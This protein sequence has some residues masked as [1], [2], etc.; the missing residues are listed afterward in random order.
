MYLYI[1]PYILPSL[2]LLVL[3][4]IGRALIKARQ[5]GEKTAAD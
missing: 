3:F 2:A 4:F 5:K 1:E